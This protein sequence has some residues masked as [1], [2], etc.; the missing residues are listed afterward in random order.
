MV[1]PV[2][3][4]G[5]R[6]YLGVGVTTPRGINRV[7]LTCGRYLLDNWPGDCV[8]VLPT[9]WGMRVYDRTLSRETVAYVEQKWREN[10]AADNDPAYAYLRSRLIDG[11]L[12]VQDDLSG[13]KGGTTRPALPTA[14]AGLYRILRDTGV[15]WGKS[16]VRAAPNGAIYLNVGQMAW[17]MPTITRWLRH[18]PDI[19]AVFMLHDVLPLE[20]PEF[21]SGP[22]RM[23]MN[24]MLDAVIARAAGLITNTQ[25]ASDAIMAVLR[26]RGLPDLP[27]CVAHLPVDD[28]FLQH[29]PQNSELSQN[30]YFL[31]CGAIEQRKNLS[32][33]L[34]VWRRLVQQLGPAAP[35]LVVAGSAVPNALSIM[36]ELQADEA[37]RRHIIVV[38]GLSSAHVRRLMANARAVIM[39]SL[40]EGFGLPIIEALTV[41]TPVL[42]SDIPAHREVGGDR[43]WYRDPTDEAGWTEA[44][45]RLAGPA[46]AAVDALRQRVATYTPQTAAAYF[47]VVGDFLASLK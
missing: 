34:R 25:A 6:L 7:D 4:D 32:M 27:V 47:D 35:R 2:I 8:G 20:Q 45:M 44:I 33:L 39:A 13:Y 23:A 43:A 11:S 22:A 41:G 28:L 5:L 31:V 29:E 37:M 18:R 9:P 26:A 17:A 24:W 15:K 3:C 14:V 12:A 38:S 40:A 46:D 21:F 42:A 30:P 1:A 16:A 10:S 19:R 36:R